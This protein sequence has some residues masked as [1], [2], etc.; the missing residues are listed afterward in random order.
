MTH[1]VK[2]GVNPRGSHLRQFILPAALPSP[3]PS[4]LALHNHLLSPPPQTNQTHLWPPTSP[5]HNH[6]HYHTFVFGPDP[7]RFYVHTFN[8]IY[9][10][11]LHVCKHI[12]ASHRYI[13]T[14]EAMK[15][16]CNGRENWRYLSLFPHTSQNFPAEFGR[17]NELAGW[18]WVLTWTVW[19]RFFFLFF[20]Y[21]FKWI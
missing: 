13:R 4:F 3:P 1:E 21:I 8:Y 19:R 9:A 7:S 20:I 16:N 6:L 10:Q 18:G 14:L 12:Y 17:W 15:L 5:L 2:K 11:V